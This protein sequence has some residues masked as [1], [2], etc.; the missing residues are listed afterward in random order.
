MLRFNLELHTAGTIAA[1]FGMAN[2]FARPLGG[3]MSEAAARHFGMRGRL[4]EPL[5]PT[6]PR[7]YIL[8]LSRE[9]RHSSP[10]HRSSG[11][12]RRHIRDHPVHL[13]QIA[14]RHLGPHRCRWELGVRV[15]PDVVIYELE[16]LDSHWDFLHGDHDCGVHVAG[17][18]G[19]FSSV[20]EHVFSGVEELQ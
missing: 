4:C 8:H 20:G 10:L 17:G 13:S 11:R 14:W 16:L 6:N 5:H 15:D 9:S 3:Y 19:A 7:G 12:M 1:T 2:I 18:G